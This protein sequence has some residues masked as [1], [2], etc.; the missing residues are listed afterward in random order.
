MSL[1]HFTHFISSLHS[2]ERE[3]KLSESGKGKGKSEKKSS[4]KG[5][6]VKTA[7]RKIKQHASP[8]HSFVFLEE[9]TTHYNDDDDVTIICSN[10]S[11]CIVLFLPVYLFI[12]KK[13]NYI[14]LVCRYICL[15]I[16]LIEVYLFSFSFLFCCHCHH[17]FMEC[18]KL[19]IS[20][21][22]C[23]EC[24]VLHL[25]C[26]CVL[27]GLNILRFNCP[28]HSSTLNFSTIQSL[29]F[30]VGFEWKGI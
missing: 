9:M 3:K 5:K 28:F 17:H 8:N 29:Y 21:F 24:V 14:K 19:L 22:L 10:L 30:I 27:Y 25:K 15:Y 6:G 4:K 16:S 18:R 26:V 20:H 12:T 1:F 23:M 7:Q 13:S 11:L 2:R